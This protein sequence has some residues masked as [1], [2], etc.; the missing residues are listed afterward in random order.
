MSRKAWLW[1]ISLLVIASMVLAACQTPATQAPAG[2]EPAAEEPAAEEPAA[3]APAAEEPAA[4]EPA[5][6]EPAGDLETLMINLGTYPDIMDPQKSSFVNEIAH[7]KLIYEGLT[8]LDNDLNTVPGAA[9]S[10]D[11][12]E[13]STQL[14]FT[15]R[16]GLKY[17]DGSLLNAKRFEYSILRNIDPVTA[18]EYATITD[19]IAGAIEW[20]SADVSTA[21]EEELQALKDAVQVKALDSAGNPCTGYDQE[22]CRTL[23]IGLRQP[24]PYFH[25]VMSLWVTYPAR[26]EDITAGGEDWWSEA[27]NHVGNGPFVFSELEPSVRGFFVPNQNYWRG[28]PTYNIEYRYITDTAVAFESY[29]NDEFDIITAGAEDFPV[30][31]ADPVLNEELRVY[32]GSCTYAIMFHQLKEPFTDQKV[33]EAF[34]Y[35]LNREGWVNDVLKGLGSPTLTWIPP[36]FPGYDAEEDRYAFDPE[37]AKQALA[38]SSYGSAEALPPIELTFSDTPRNRTRFEWLANQ[39]KEVLG[40]E[41]TLNPVESTTYT[42]LTKDINTAPQVFLLGWCADYPDPQNWLSVYWKTGAFGERIGFSNPELDELLNKADSET[43]PATRAQMYAD[44]Q[45]LLVSSS[46]VAFMWNNVNS[47]LVKPRVQGIVETPQDS[48]WPGDNDP[49]TITV[50][51]RQ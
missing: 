37:K 5:A 9:E 39:W 44:A 10:W 8:R 26:E 29:K 35:A 47:Y 18:G 20:R 19:D 7:L 23:V 34:A 24:A 46:P 45:K 12:N 43:D 51:P 25:T 36:G 38:E 11:Y 16:E 22:D 3:E 6:E 50:E 27:A 17:S 4:Q 32:P 30:I 41:T 48:G 2:E 31:K 28:A 14:T 13:D 1:I 40:V 42:A 49:T 15:L 33:R 21:T